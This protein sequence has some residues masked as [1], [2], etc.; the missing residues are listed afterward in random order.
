MDTKEFS[1]DCMKYRKSTHL[2]SV[3]VREIIREKGSCELTIKLAYYEKGVSVNGKK[4]DAYFIAFEEPLKE[5]MPNSGNRKIISRLVQAK[6][7]CT[8]QEA[9]IISKWTGLKIKLLFDPNRTFGGEITGGILVDATYLEVPKLTLA[10]AKREFSLVCSRE[11]FEECM[12][13]FPEFMANPEILAEC[14][15]LSVTYPNPEA[16]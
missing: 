9:M 16:K 12:R 4:T 13:M 1:I 2:A 11:S 10:D 6:Y 7:N 14:K 15:K 8:L 3:D 5:F